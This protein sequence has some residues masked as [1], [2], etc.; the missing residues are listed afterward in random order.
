M[1]VS[2]CGFLW[3]DGG[4]KKQIVSEFETYV[5]QFATKKKL[6]LLLLLHL[7]LACMQALALVVSL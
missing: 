5:C 1:L 4:Q 2:M 7:R 6:V 3:M